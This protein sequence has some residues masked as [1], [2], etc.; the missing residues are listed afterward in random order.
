M[1]REYA[2]IR[3]DMGTDDDFRR[4]SPAAQHLYFQLLISPTLS[5]CGVAD[6]RPGR[7]AALAGGW[8]AKAVRIAA[9]ELAQGLFVVIDDDSEE[10]LV[11]SFI[12]HDGLLRNP[13]TSVSMVNAFGAVASPRIRGV[14]VHELKKIRQAR[15]DLAAWTSDKAAPKVVALLAREAID[16]VDLGEGLPQGQGVDY[17]QGLGERFTQGLP[18]GLR[19]THPEGLPVGLGEGFLPAPA[20]APSSSSQSGYVTGVPHQ[21]GGER[22]TPSKP[23][24]PT[25]RPVPRCARHL[26]HP[27]PP[28]CRDCAEARTDAERWD[29]EQRVAAARANSAKVRADAEARLAE[30]DACPLGCG[31]SEPRG[32]LNGRPCHHDPAQGERNAVGADRVRQ[33]L[34][35]A[36]ARRDAAAQ[37][38]ADGTPGPSA[39]DGPDDQ[40]V[41]L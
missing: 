38:P 35:E 15:P 41:A 6:W 29:R 19:E 12:K 11:R 9:D 23:S 40:A 20:P 21:G 39:T 13:K 8:S 1:A 16:P 34:A 14:I 18:E 25:E 37:A 26:N 22:S 27:N 5:Y 33:A 2:Q 36:K 28:N 31:E 4:L 17:P 3:L 32:Y 7:I 10:I 24:S 30:I